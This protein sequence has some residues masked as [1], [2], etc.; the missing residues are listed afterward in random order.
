MHL[1]ERE[2]SE[3]DMLTKRV[4]ELISRIEQVTVKCSAEIVLFRLMAYRS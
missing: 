4:L 1:N 3:L 2:A